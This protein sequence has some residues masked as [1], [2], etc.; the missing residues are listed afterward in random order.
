M[1]LEKPSLDSEVPIFASDIDSDV[2][3]NSKEIILFRNS[4]P[5]DTIYLKTGQF[6]FSN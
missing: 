2:G 3:R 1:R 6:I 5:Q 4:E